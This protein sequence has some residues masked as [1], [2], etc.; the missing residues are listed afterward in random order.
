MHVYYN[1]EGLLPG[2]MYAF[3]LFTALLYSMVKK[4]KFNYKIN[5]IICFNF[6]YNVYIVYNKYL[7]T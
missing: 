5:I 4:Y 2:K 3:L 7:N 1:M 6:I